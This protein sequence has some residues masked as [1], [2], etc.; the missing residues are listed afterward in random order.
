MRKTTKKQTVYYAHAMC[1]Y[2]RRD[3]RLQLAHIRKEFRPCTVVN[4]ANFDG[5]PDKVNDTVGFCLK[6]IDESDVVVFARLLGKVTAGVGKEVNYALKTGKL[7]FELQSDRIVRRFRRV[8]Y[9]SRRATIS[10]YE[11]YRDQ[12]FLPEPG[13]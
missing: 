3:E 1:L 6:L 13:W 10:L 8:N 7:V 9:I 11:K 2:G 4:P 12:F 5:H